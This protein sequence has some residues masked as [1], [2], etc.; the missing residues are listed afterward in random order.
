MKSFLRDCASF[1]RSTFLMV[2]HVCLLVRYNMIL[3]YFLEEMY[4]H[5]QFNAKQ[6][7]VLQRPDQP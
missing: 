2:Y 6:N 1:R 3:A 4:R 5:F 7:A